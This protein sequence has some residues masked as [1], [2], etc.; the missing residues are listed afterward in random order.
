[1]RYIRDIQDG[2]QFWEIEITNCLFAHL[3]NYNIFILIHTG[4]CF[5][6]PQHSN[7]LFTVETIIIFKIIRQIDER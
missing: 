3:F 5:H 4:M 7:T 6:F 1:M 2:A